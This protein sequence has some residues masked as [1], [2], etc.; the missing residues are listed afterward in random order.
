[1]KCRKTVALLLLGLVPATAWAQIAHVQ[2]VHKA[3]TNVSEASSTTVAITPSAGN[4]L[5]LTCAWF[6]GQGAV[7][8]Y[9]DN[10][11][12]TWQSAIIGS[13]DANS[14]IQ[15]AYAM[16]VAGAATTITLQQGAGAGSGDIEC[17][18]IE[19]SGA[20]TTGALDVTPTPT[21][22]SSTTPA[23]ASGTLAQSDE[24][25]IAMATHTGGDATWAVDTGGGYTQISEN[26]DNDTGQTYSAQRKIVAATT[27]DTADWTLGASRSWTAI[28]A[29]FKGVGGGP[30]PTT[31]KLL[32]L[33][34]G[35]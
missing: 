12:N 34:V 13:P 10:Q 11:A 1:M 28:L 6:Q 26:E 3:R 27:S 14:H 25:L 20:A 16:N 32:L 18:V 35:Q 15:I 33:G 4:L 7:Y 24:V 2:T 8:S 30:P 5:V 22:G 29:S 9:S 19:F 23:I 31:P 21:T 17:D